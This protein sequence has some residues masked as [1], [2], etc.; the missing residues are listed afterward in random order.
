M[1]KT[2]KL[3]YA[4]GIDPKKIEYEQIMT[5]NE[6]D[7]TF[8]KWGHILKPTLANANNN[9]IKS[10]YRC[11]KQD[12]DF[13]D[14]INKNTV[15]Y[16]HEA[17]HDHVQKTVNTSLKDSKLQLIK[18]YDTHKGR[19]H[20]WE[21]VSD[22][23]DNVIK[24]SLKVNDIVQVGMII[25]NGIQTDIALGID[26]FTKRLSCTNGAISA[27]RSEGNISISHVGTY[28]YMRD[29]FTEAIPYAIEKAKELIY[30]Y[31]ES[32]YIKANQKLAEEFYSQLR[33]KITPSYFPDNFNL[34]LDKAKAE[35]EAISKIVKYEPK[36][37]EKLW[38]VFNNFTEKIWH[39]EKLSFTGIRKTETALHKVLIAQLPNQ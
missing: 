7:R 12:G 27:A 38:D 14:F 10:G 16:P 5:Y 34:D 3:T 31:Q 1:T 18:E 39:S 21:Y 35:P 8:E 4:Q 32:A 37:E 11:W 9:I 2:S 22:L 17:V 19:S 15:F 20:Y 28:E 26:F 6:P 25:R 13:M 24:G 23:R 29:R 30:Y 36:K 33:N